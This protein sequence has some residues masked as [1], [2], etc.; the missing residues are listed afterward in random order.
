LLFIFFYFPRNFS[1]QFFFIACHFDLD[2]TKYF[3]TRKQIP[4]S[5]C[6]KYFTVDYWRK[7][8]GN[9]KLIVYKK[10]RTQAL[11]S[12]LL[13]GEAS[14]SSAGPRCVMGRSRDHPMMQRGPAEEAEEA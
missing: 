4:F 5:C 8:G 2:T 1:L 14:A 3:L 12:T 10:A 7:Y 9:M 11:S 13:A 6:F